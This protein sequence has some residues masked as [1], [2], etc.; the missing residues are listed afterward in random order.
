L[1]EKLLEIVG[2]GFIAYKPKN[3]ACVLVVSQVKGLKK[4]I[5]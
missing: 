4:I 1:A 5:E 2:Y 3:N